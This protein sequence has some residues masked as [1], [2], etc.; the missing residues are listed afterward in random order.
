MEFPIL[1]SRTSTGAIQTWLIEVWNDKYRTITGQLDG[2]KVVN[3]WTTC[4]GKSIGR[5]SETTAEE[6]AI[7][8]AKSIWDKKKK[9]KGYFEDINLIDIS[10]FLEPML[11]KKFVDRLSKVTY[12][13]MVD[14]KYNGMR[15]IT[16]ANGQTTRN[17][18]LI[19]SAPHTFEA[20]RHLF[21]EHPDLV[22]DGELYNNDY[23]YK[24]NEI[25][26]IVR[27]T[28]NVTAEVLAESKLKVKY[29]IYDGYNFDVPS[30]GRV[31]TDTYCSVRRD[32][33]KDLF[34][35]IPFVEVV[36]YAW[37]DT[38]DDV[39]RIYDQ[40]VYDGYEGAMVRMDAEYENKR[41][42]NLLKVKPTDD[43]EFEII[44]VVE[45]EG[46]RSKMAGKV[47]VK[48]KDG[49]TFGCGMKGS[50]PQF[51]EALK[52]KQNYI[53]QIATIYYN[54]FTGKGIPNFAQFD[55]NNY[56]K[57]DR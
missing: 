13:V 41:S 52:N 34:K 23:R 19:I 22:I 51:E 57:G 1:Y 20:V 54:G 45:G 30:I 37:A 40:Y 36:D 5:S 8:D 21:D 11:A 14:R 9:S 44:D 50:V 3:E 17:N 46:N 29:Y 12:P 10:T 7:K 2:K 6:Q 26:S 33:L 25:I 47:I 16:T 15:C 24:L 49:R 18:E 38:E 56:N 48:M 31:E 32:A 43:D 4:Q 27:K 35:G 53:G 42:N 28:K 39:W 55:C